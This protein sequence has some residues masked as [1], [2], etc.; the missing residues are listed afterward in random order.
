MSEVSENSN[1]LSELSQDGQIEKG[2]SKSQIN[3]EL[4]KA[5]KA[6][7]KAE[8]KAKAAPA[9]AS[10]APAAVEEIEDTFSH[11]YGDLP[12]VQSTQITDKAYRLISELN[13]KYCGQ[14]IWIRARVATSR[15]VGKGCFML[16]RQSTESIQ[17][18]IFQGKNT[19]K[20]MVKYC[21]AISLESVVD[22]RAQITAPEIPIQS[23]TTK[24]LE[25]LMLE[26]HLVS[27]AAE[28]PFLVDDAGRSDVEAEKTGLPV[29]NQDTALNFRWIDTRTPANQ[30]IFRIQ[31][32]VCQLF[33][34]YLLNNRFLEIH[35]PK[36]IGGASEG[37]ANVFTL[38]YFEQP[39]CLAQSP[40]FYKQ[41]SAACGGFE[42]V[43]EIGPVFRAE[44]SNT[45]RHLCEFTGL[46]FEMTIYEHYYEALEVM[47][48]LFHFIFDGIAEKFHHELT[49]ISQQYPFEPLQTIRPALR[50]TFQ[51]GISMLNEAGFPAPYDED[52][53]TPNEKQL[54][55]LVKEKYQTD[56]YIMDKYPLSVRPFYTMPDPNDPTL[57]NS[58]DLFIRGEEIVSG[59]QR[60]HDVDM[61]IERAK[62]W[63]V[64]IESIQ[65][66][67]DAFK[68][69]AS[70]H[71][72]GGIGL[73]RVVM[74]YLGLK[75][76]RK[77][78]MFPRDPNRLAP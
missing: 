2:P 41:I 78:S 34:E 27:R 4:R 68:H 33:R 11:L 10:N 53:S 69:G 28:L 66:Y 56:F 18:V 46:D 24:N 71:A 1:N 50:L 49:L 26:I 8:A 15:A 48:G 47:S 63:N 29:V 19:P 75:N 64:P 67:V 3:K 7:K 20:A 52:I 76:I 36:L 61:L 16:L 37:G 25:L 39:A 31:S 43:F 59:A 74:L 21:T 40:Q 45:N 14:T 17:A 38:K 13:E 9:Q 12:L 23:A 6:A 65:S 72:G 73:E 55:K 44:N 77:S 5:E 62:H 35:T 60:V 54:G 30:A 57:S 51:E 42:R 32:G 22:I 58:Y 70:P